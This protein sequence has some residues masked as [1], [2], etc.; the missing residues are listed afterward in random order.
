MY[1]IEKTIQFDKW[2]RKLKDLKAKSRILFRIQKIE[3][4]GHLGDCTFVGDGI[5]ELRIDSGKGYR[6]Y[7]REKEG[8]IIL[9][10]IGGSKSSQQ[11]D[12]EKAKLIWNNLKKSHEHNK[13]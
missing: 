10:L 2:F 13:I 12:I 6:L 5:H 4:D 1:F 9:L 11:R 7:F 3:T 8:R